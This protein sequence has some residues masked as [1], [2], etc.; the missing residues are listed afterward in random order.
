MNRH[1]YDNID[2]GIDIIVRRWRPMK[3][4]RRRANSYGKWRP[5]KDIRRKANSYGK[6]I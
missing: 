6:F 4:M 5:M 3:D 1:S 2:N